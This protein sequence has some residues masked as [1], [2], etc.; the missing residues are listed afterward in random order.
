[1]ANTFFG[2]TIA[3]TGLTASNIAINTTAHNISNVNTEGYT[4]Q[5]A[6]QHNASSVRVYANYG[7]VGTGVEVT[8]IDQIR[9]SYYDTKYWNNNAYSAQY[10][11]FESY[12]SLIEGYLDEFNLQGFNT[13]YENIMAAVNTLVND[14]PSSDVARNQFMNYSQSLC[15]YFNT[16]SA[17]LSN[18]QKQANDEVKSDVEA[19]NTIAEKIASLNK[20]INTIEV[21]GANAN[22]LYD[23]R[24]LLVD[25]LSR[26][27]NTSTDIL[28]LDTGMTEFRVY[29]N[30]QPLVDCYNYNKLTC[31]AR[32]VDAKRNAS[33]IEGLYDIKWNNNLYLDIY[34]DTIKGALKAAIDI[35]D[36]C[37]NGYEVRGLVD[38][39]GNFYKQSGKIVDIQ[40]LSDADIATLK[41]SGYSERLVMYE[42]SY[43]NS[44]FK[45]IAFYK[46]ELNRFTQI[47]A[48]EFNAIIAKGDLGKDALGNPNKVP[49]FFVSQFG[50]EYVSAANL[51]VNSIVMQ[52]MS[53][54]PF[55]Y[56]NSKGAANTDM[57]A[58]LLALKNKNTIDNG[59]F[60]ER[61]KSIVSIIAVDSS[62]IKTFAKNYDNIKATIE[63]QRK[64]VSG[65]DENEEAVDMMKF[66]K[67]YNLSSKV[68]QTMQEIYDRLILQTGV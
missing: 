20:Q 41:A 38:A 6:I 59:T 48:D 15:K 4:R 2:L 52:D 42:D 29:I 56:D 22:D 60:S 10:E 8:S 49:D 39:S 57:V 64:S 3:S 51:S 40:T 47:F 36:G 68:I 5:K 63:R 12:E 16:L 18:V 54:L 61:L 55:S 9:S 45:G 11:R 21:N 53:L 33:D 1:M 23:A 13:E 66:Q 26:Y 58:D 24:N 30:N 35:R 28:T 14:D 17:N 37:G 25:E 43:H 67:S 65:V 32:E 31:V 19:I 34:G 62:N 44:D 27:V 50:D 7:T 46:G